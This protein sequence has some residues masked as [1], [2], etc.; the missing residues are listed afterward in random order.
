MIASSSKLN[1]SVAR[2]AFLPLF[3]SC[4]LEKLFR[5]F[6]VNA[7]L[8]PVVWLL[9]DSASLAVAIFA[10]CHI[11][12]NVLRRNK[13][14]ANGHVTVRPVRRIVLQHFLSVLLKEL[15]R[16]KALS[17]FRK[18][19][20]AAASGREQRFVNHGGLEEVHYTFVAVYMGA[21]SRDCFRERNIRQTSNALSLLNGCCW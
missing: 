4:C 12:F 10:C 1:H 14:Q 7:V 17:S 19:I 21:R 2:V 20:L 11:V 15:C 9:A 8:I 3:L 13:L 18:H 5:L 6:I 16:Q